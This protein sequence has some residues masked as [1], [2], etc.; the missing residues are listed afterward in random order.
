MNV[1]AKNDYGDYIT[2][3]GDGA[4]NDYELYMSSPTRHLT[5]FNSGSGGSPTSTNKSNQILKVMSN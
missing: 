5:I 1:L 3:G 4:G 2:M